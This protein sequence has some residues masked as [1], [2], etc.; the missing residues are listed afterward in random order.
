MNWKQC[1]VIVLPCFLISGMLST[2]G[3]FFVKGVEQ[4]SFGSF[5]F[6]VPFTRLKW[7]SCIYYFYCIFNLSILLRMQFMSISLHMFLWQ[8]YSLFYCIFNLYFIVY[9]IYVYFITY[10][11][12]NILFNR[13]TQNNSKTLILVLVVSVHSKTF[14]LLLNNWM[15]H[16]I[17]NLINI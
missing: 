4:V 10:V 5:F 1:T 9:A 14:W 17:I 15:Y 13:N 8:L 7:Q 12:W 11:F 6:S 2:L 3:K 16:G